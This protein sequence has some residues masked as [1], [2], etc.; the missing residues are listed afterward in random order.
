MNQLYE[1]QQQ[2]L[3][4]KE[5]IPVKNIISDAGLVKR[6]TQLYQLRNEDKLNRN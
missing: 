4:V 1:R 3:T 2:I 5:S 6:I